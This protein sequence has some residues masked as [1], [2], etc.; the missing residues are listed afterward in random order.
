MSTVA[1]SEFAPHGVFS[2]CFLIE[3]FKYIQTKKSNIMN[4]HQPASI[5]TNFWLFWFHLYFHPLLSSWHFTNWF[6]SSPYFLQLKVRFTYSCQIFWGRKLHRWH[7]VFMLHYSCRDTRTFLCPL[8]VVAKPPLR[9]RPPCSFKVGIGV[10]SPRVT[11]W[12]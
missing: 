4:P 9:W 8:L 6:S 11:P 5:I 2:F 10:P 7:H 12:C 1:C 3:N